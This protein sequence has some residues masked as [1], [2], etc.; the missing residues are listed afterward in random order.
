M[1]QVDILFFVHFDKGQEIVLIRN[2][3]LNYPAEV[4]L[5]VKECNC[6]EMICWTAFNKK[7]EIVKSGI[8][9]KGE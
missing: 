9:N 7:K 6:T 2:V 3:D 8:I 5:R 1:E 4:E